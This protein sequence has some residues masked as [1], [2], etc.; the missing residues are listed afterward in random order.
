MRRAAFAGCMMVLAGSSGAAAQSHRT[1]RLQLHPAQSEM[2]VIPP[3]SARP[4]NPAPPG[5]QP[6]QPAPAI[7][8]LPPRAGAPGSVTLDDLARQGYDV[9]TTTAI[10]S[11]PGRFMV[12]MQRAGDVRTCMMR[13][14]AGGGQQPR[15]QSICF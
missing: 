11:Q 2:P 1:V 3:P 9:K 10:G 6:Q 8:G 7:P 14:E 15:R 13:I 4:Q 5:T 12:M